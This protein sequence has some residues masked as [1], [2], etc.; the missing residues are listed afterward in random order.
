ML[1]RFIL[2]YAY[3]AR[4]AQHLDLDERMTFNFTRAHYDCHTRTVLFEL[5]RCMVN[6]KRMLL[7]NGQDPRDIHAHG[8]VALHAWTAYTTL[9]DLLPAGRVYSLPHLPT[10]PRGRVTHARTG[11]TYCRGLPGFHAG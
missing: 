1:F 9:P 8:G 4:Y 2:L 5:D 10:L 6:N 3:N 11:F 7:D